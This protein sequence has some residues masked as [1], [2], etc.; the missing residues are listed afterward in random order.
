MPTYNGEQY[1]ATALESVRQQS[2]DDIEIVVADD[3]SSDS[4]LEVVRGFESS[5]K[6]KLLTPPKAGNWVAMTNVALK[7]ATGEW[8][9]FL[10]QDDLWLPGRL[11]KIREEL[12]RAKGKMVLHNA[13]FV[14]PDGRDLGPWTCPF[15]ADEIPSNEFVERL[16]VQNFIAIP[17]PVFKRS[18]ALDSGGLDESLWFTADWD[19]WLRLGAM[20]PVRFTP[21]KLAAFRVHALS[22]TASRKL[23]PGDWENQLMTVFDRHFSADVPIRNRQRVRKLASASVCVNSELAAASRGQRVR[24]ARIFIKLLS[25]GPAGLRRYL[26]DSRITERVRSRM[27]VRKKL[28]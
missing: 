7:A 17:S 4:T 14:G 28:F 10:H 3:S 25:L 19:L 20:G 11:T 9:C 27:K 2:S 8:V 13:Q 21:E 24:P 16:L 26:K 18:A 22:Q 23:S 6:I 12:N 5:L 1:V 15:T